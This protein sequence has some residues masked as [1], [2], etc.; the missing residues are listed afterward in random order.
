MKM[1]HIIFTLALH[2]F[3][4]ATLECDRATENRSSL[5]QQL[6]LSLQEVFPELMVDSVMVY[7]AEFTVN[8]YS[9]E[10]LP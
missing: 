7:Y 8:I 1:Q 4:T 6:Y 3:N 2:G 5:K 10:D 9:K